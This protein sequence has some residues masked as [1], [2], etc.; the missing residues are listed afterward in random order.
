MLKRNNA[1]VTKASEISSFDAG[2]RLTHLKTNRSRKIR[3]NNG[4]SVSAGINRYP[5][6][7]ADNLQKVD[8]HAARKR[9]MPFTA[10]TS[11]YRPETDH[12]AKVSGFHSRRNANTRSSS[13]SSS[14]LPI[15]KNASIPITNAPLVARTAATK[16]SR[17]ESAP[18]RIKRRNRP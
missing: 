9:N 8:S 11:Q 7:F 1:A 12:N 3:P 16:P 5:T 4:G 2:S 10:I 13:A 18:L 14:P 15:D 17:E 6:V